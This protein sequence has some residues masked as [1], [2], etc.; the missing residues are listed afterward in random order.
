MP[1]ASIQSSG[2]SFIAGDSLNLTCSVVVVPNN[3]INDPLITWTGPGVNTNTVQVSREASELS[4]VFSTLL[5]SHGGVYTCAALITIP[6]AGVSVNATQFIVMNVQ[7]KF[8][9]GDNSN[10]VR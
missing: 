4:L 5:S 9:S 1:V 2:D 10:C 7:S 6:E 8:V 3:L